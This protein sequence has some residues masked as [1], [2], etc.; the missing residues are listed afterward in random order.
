MTK[1]QQGKKSVLAKNRNAVFDT[2]LYITEIIIGFH[3]TFQLSDK[4]QKGKKANL[5]E[6]RNST[7]DTA[8]HTYI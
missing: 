6:N 2:A 7:F 5:S 8:L 1:R 4:R 3:A